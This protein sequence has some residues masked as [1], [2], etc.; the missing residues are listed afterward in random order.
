MERAKPAGYDIPVECERG[1]P[2][3]NLGHRLLHC[4]GTV[5]LRATH[6]SDAE[7]LRLRE[8]PPQD[9]PLNLGFQLV[10]EFRGEPPPGTGFEFGEFGCPN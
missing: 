9:A 8:H 10:P 3:D 4:P 2:S 5:T 1:H 6:F 7:L